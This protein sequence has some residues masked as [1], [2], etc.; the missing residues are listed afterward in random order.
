MRQVWVRL[1]CILVEA[2]NSPGHIE[3]AVYQGPLP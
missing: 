1:K 3:A 2:F